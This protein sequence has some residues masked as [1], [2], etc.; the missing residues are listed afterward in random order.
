M[1]RKTCVNLLGKIQKD[2]DLNDLEI[3]GSYIHYNGCVF[4]RKHVSTMF[5]YPE[6]IVS[7]KFTSSGVEADIEGGI[8]RKRLSA[9]LLK[10]AKIKKQIEVTQ[11]MERHFADAVEV[12]NTLNDEPI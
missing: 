3:K 8:P 11:S 10:Q 1:D 2:F 7:V 12:F 9:F 5:G 6:R 4:E